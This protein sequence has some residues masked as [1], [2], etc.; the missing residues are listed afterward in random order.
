[1]RKL[2]GV[3]RAGKKAHINDGAV[4]RLWDCS[5]GCRII[6]RF[7]SSLVTLHGRVDYRSFDKHYYNSVSGFYIVI[8]SYPA[9]FLQRPRELIT[10]VF[11][12]VRAGNQM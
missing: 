1:M 11:T 8:R 5:V 3:V 6:S 10:L 7:E 9:R 12:Y 2:A 4:A